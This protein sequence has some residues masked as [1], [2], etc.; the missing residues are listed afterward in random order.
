M[1]R[2]LIVDDE[3]PCR[4]QLE[5]LLS[6]QDDIEV[7]GKV[8]NLEQAREALAMSHHH[9]VFLDVHLRQ[10]SG[11]DLVPHI[12]PNTAIIFVTAFDRYAVRAFDINAL[13]YL[14]KP[15]EPERLAKALARLKQRV[16]TTGSNAAE[17]PPFE[18][19]DQVY[20]RTD[21]GHRFASIGDIVSITSIGGNYT[22]VA[23]TDG[24]Q[25]AI[26]RTLKEWQQRLPP[27]QFLRVHRA[28]LINVVHVSRVEKRPKGTQVLYLS[29]I[30]EPIAIS[31]R[32][33]PNV[34]SVLRDN[35]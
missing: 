6:A 21:K 3:P 13:D 10:Q 24:S 16:D 2:A 11:F 18:C 26:R 17:L 23:L 27:S 7:A 4:R 12:P 30:D 14:T 9:V 32:C 8:A 33:L 20:L 29:G 34:L 15:V 22:T 5:Y 31:R 28:C 1:I 19:S 35:D 25:P